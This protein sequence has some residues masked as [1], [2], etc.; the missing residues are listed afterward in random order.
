MTPHETK[1]TSPLIRILPA[2]ATYLC[3][4]TW[5]GTRLWHSDQEAR[6]IYALSPA[7]GTVLREFPCVWV[8]ADLTHDGTHLC[9][10]GGRPKR[11]VL[12]DAE[13]GTVKGHKEVAPASGRLTGLELAPDGL[14]MC[15]RGPTVVQLRDYTTMTVLREYP[16]P[17]DSPSGLTVAGD[18][19]VY[20]DVAEAVLRTLDSRTGK[21]TGVISVPGRPTGLTWDGRQLWYCDFPGRAI[22]SL[23]L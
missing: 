21:I 4:L 13:T 1:A 22:R 9:Q 12:V 8:R 10:V 16:V 3:G 20:G 11:I 18:L 6:K 19:I 7:T 15:L 14:W 23:G 5:D 17:G 2:P